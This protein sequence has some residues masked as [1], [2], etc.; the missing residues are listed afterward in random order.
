[1]YFASVSMCV[2]VYVHCMCAMHEHMCAQASEGQRSKSGFISLEP[3]TPFQGTVSRWDLNSPNWVG[4]M[5]YPKPKGLSCL[6]L[7]L[8]DFRHQPPH[9]V[10]YMAYNDQPPALMAKQ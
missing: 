9:M 2:H 3:C 5:A 4:L 1:M 8:W 6:P 10:F 7:Q